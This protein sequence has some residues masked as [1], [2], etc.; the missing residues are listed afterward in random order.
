MDDLISRR[1]AI[2]AVEAECEFYAD[3]CEY[4][5]AKGLCLALEVI[6]RLPSAQKPPRSEEDEE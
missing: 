5:K 2:E 3:L 6:E 4:E 1:A